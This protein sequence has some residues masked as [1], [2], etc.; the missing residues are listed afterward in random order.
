MGLFRR[1]RPEPFQPRELPDAWRTRLHVRWPAY[2]TLDD[3]DRR[4]LDHLTMEFL[5]R[6][7]FEGAQGF[8]VTD[9]MRVL[10]AAQA[11]LLLIGLDP[12]TLD[13]YSRLTSVIL[14]PRTVVLR[15]AHR[16]T[17]DLHSDSAQALS[18]QAH[19]RGPVVLAWSTVA[20]EARHPDRGQNVVLHE[21]AHQLDMDDG[22]VDGTPPI[23]DR[24]LRERWVSVCTAEYRRV[25]RGDESVLRGYAATDTGEFFA[26]ATETFFTQPHR[27]REGAPA[28][29]ELFHD[30]YGQNPA[31]RVPPPPD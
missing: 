24:A 4:T 18:G 23:A 10:V 11:S 7:R 17:G 13:L 22:I 8:E 29:Y 15:G 19:H 20:F 12:P 21:F 30:L 9:E 5:D 1:S 16:V 14:H 25:R 31:G 26:V 2:A 6:T 3:T 27:M 28:L